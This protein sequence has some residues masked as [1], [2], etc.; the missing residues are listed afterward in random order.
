MKKII[1]LPFLL[2]FIFSSRAQFKYVSALSGGE[3]G[4]CTV[5]HNG[6]FLF[7]NHTNEITIY[8]ISSTSGLLTKKRS[9]VNPDQ[10]EYTFIVLT[11]DD[12]F[13]YTR[14]H[15][16]KDGK[17]VSVFR[18]FSMNPQTA[19]TKLI[20][21][22]EGQDGSTFDYNANIQISPKGNFILVSS[23]SDQEM[24]V[25]KRNS[26]GSL[27][28]LSKTVSPTLGMFNEF[29]MSADERFLYVASQNLY[30]AMAVYSFDK[31]SGSLNSM[32]Q[33]EN[34]NYRHY[35]SDKFVITP[36]GK[37][38][39]TIGSD[40][41]ATDQTQNQ[42]TIYNRDAQ[43]GM[44]SYAKTLTNLKSDGIIEISFLYMDGSGE[45]L[46]ACTSL[47][48]DS[49]AVH[50]YKADPNTGELKK[51]Q[52]FNDGGITSKLRGAYG[53]SFTPN[54][55]F[56]Y[57]TAARDN[58]ITIFENS[59]PKPSV[60]MR[61]EVV[62]EPIHQ[63]E[64]DPIVTNETTNTNSGTTNSNTSSGSSSGASSANAISK[65]LYAEAWK[66]I[67]AES[68]DGTRLDLSYQLLEGK[69][70]K[71]VQIAAMAMLFTSE[72]KRLE[73]VK[74]MSYFVIDKENYRLL[75]DLFT[76]DS[77]KDD[78]NKTLK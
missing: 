53:V 70:M 24:Y 12:K 77:I 68:S 46:I 15:I 62:V 22:L 61:E 23:N 72:Y 50:T 57:V 29:Q 52:T 35:N 65:E 48:A 76:Y 51:S 44:L 21:S 4:E 43:S 66:K 64:P 7:L 6:K 16:K 10:Q 34:P 45:N 18:M 17:F 30:K 78:F 13:L 1:L 71:T 28:H 25:Y 56:M 36:N 31:N 75:V 20:G 40:S 11:P 33:I 49:H 19:E 3:M 37:F 27:T 58:A 59:S 41:Y 9:L 73:F 5:S 42:I 55:K 32:Q 26:D 47:G 8:D 67:S 14:S 2:C 74:F 54:N 63:D 39:Y 60:T 69:S 38:V